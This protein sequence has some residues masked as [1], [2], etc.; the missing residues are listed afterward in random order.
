MAVFNH[1]SSP[2]FLNRLVVI[3][4]IDSSA[5]KY[6][7]KFFTYCIRILAMYAYTA[8]TDNKS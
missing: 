7:L 6:K 8:R 1:P 2:A 3:Y 5:S 4:N